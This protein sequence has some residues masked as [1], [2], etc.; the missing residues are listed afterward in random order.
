MLHLVAMLLGGAGIAP[1]ASGNRSR[2]SHRPSKA[3][4]KK[5]QVI[6]TPLTRK[7]SILKCCYKTLPDPACLCTE[8]QRFCTAGFYERL[9]TAPPPHHEE[10]QQ[11]FR[12]VMDARHSQPSVRAC[13]WDHTEVLL[14]ANSNGDERPLIREWVLSWI[15]HMD[16]FP[17]LHVVSDVA[18]NVSS[19]RGLFRAVPNVTF[20][21]LQYPFPM[22]TFYAIQWPMMWADNFTTA[23]HVLILDCDTP[24]VHSMRCHHLFN[25]RAL[26]VW[27]SWPKFFAW[28]GFTN[29][30]VSG[31]A[32]ARRARNESSVAGGKAASLPFINGRTD[33]M[34]FF[35]VVIPRAA[36]SVTRALISEAC[37]AR[38]LDGRHFQNFSGMQHG[39]VLRAEGACGHFDRAFLALSRPSYADL[40]GKAALLLAAS[41]KASF[42][43]NAS[44]TSSTSHDLPGRSATITKRALRTKGGGRGDD[45]L[46]EWYSCNS[47]ASQAAHDPHDSQCLDYVPVTE[48]VKHPILGGSEFQAWPTTREEAAKLARRL[49]AAGLAF[50]QSGGANASLIPEPFFYLKRSRPAA[51]VARIARRVL[52]P[53]PPGAFCGVPT[54]HE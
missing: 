3:P 38:A 22:N 30:M 50:G 1:A 40:I 13:K 31:V 15:T 32:A 7:Q 2:P 5:I 36:L 46:I 6:P 44:T 49:V 11:R 17:R 39:D 52:R 54:H 18:E 25:H 24:I 43:T 26:P 47:R 14:K 19:F 28:D 8:V 42:Q 51:A 41:N 10:F 29:K 53:D 12:G 34:T 27:R 4:F 21:T 23:R 35:P 9:C 48:H 33:F 16:C 45:A 37:E 20:H